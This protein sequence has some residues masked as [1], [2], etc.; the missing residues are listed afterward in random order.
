MMRRLWLAVVLG[1]ILGVGVGVF[2]S[3]TV[4]Q[5]P[6]PL[7]MPLGPITAP[8]AASEAHRFQATQA[9]S[10]QLYLLLIGLVAGFVVALPAFVFMRR[11]SWSTCHMTGTYFRGLQSRVE[12]SNL[13]RG[14]LRC[15]AWLV[16]VFRYRHPIL[17]ECIGWRIHSKWGTLGYTLWGVRVPRSTVW[18]PEA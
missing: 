17:L 2:P 1:L 9:Q 6:Q 10:S 8:G 14:R 11:V 7:N 4:A 5:P 15:R 13:P 16:L 12:T 3:H 18:T